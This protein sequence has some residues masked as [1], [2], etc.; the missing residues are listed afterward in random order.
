MKFRGIWLSLL[1]AAL[2]APGAARAQEDDDDRRPG[3]IG[4]SFDTSYDE[5]DEGV[6]IVDVRR[7]GPADEAGV[8]EGDV[9]VRLNGRRAVEAFRTL[10]E[11]LEEGDT[12][13]L[14]IRREG[15]EERDVVLVAERRPGVRFGIVRPRPG[16]RPM[17][18]MNDDS[19]EFPLEA[20]TM[21]IDS[22]H[23]R[24]LHLDSG[25][26]R[27]QL[28]SLV[29]LFN[30]SARVFIERMP[31]IELRLDGPELEALRLEGRLGELDDEAFHIESRIFDLENQAFELEGLRGE[32]FFM[33]LGRRAAAGAELAEMNE[34]LSRYFGGLT[35]GALV[36]EV[37]PNTPAARAGLEAG[38][39]ILRAGGR[40]VNGPEDVRRA[41]MAAEDGEVVLQVQRQGR[42]RELT[43]EWEARDRVIRTIRPG[44][45]EV[46]P[47]RA[48]RN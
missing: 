44:R 41:L 5:D 13:R 15:G 46:A 29:H 26:V 47:R 22:L 9:V 38:D 42:R 24:L 19:V 6:R 39:V 37:A 20:L 28:D 35:E 10:P 23:T 14:R 40:E 27:V 8:R 17:I 30:D 1:A 34:G 43:L 7:G 45:V 11:T 36:I 32:P 16:E 48:P 25:R 33:E 4:I 3:M 31:N 12:V 18:F 21:R 2:L